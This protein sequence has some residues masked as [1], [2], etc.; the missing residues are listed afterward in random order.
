MRFE[1]FEIFRP[2]TSSLRSSRVARR[3]PSF[4]ET[5]EARQLLSASLAP[6]PYTPTASPVAVSTISGTPVTVPLAGLPAQ[7]PNAPPISTYIISSA[8][9]NGK[10]LPFT[11]AFGA[12]VYAPAP[13]FVGTDTFM[14]EAVVNSQ[15]PGEPPA[16]SNPATVT[17]NVTYNYTTLSRVAVFTNGRGQI[18]NIELFW[19]GPLNA[20]LARSKAPYEIESA[21]PKGSFTGPG[22]GSI[23]IRKVRYNIHTDVVKLTPRPFFSKFKNTQLLVLGSGPSAVTAST[24][25]PISGNNGAS[26]DA[27]RLLRQSVGGVIQALPG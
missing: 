18:S 27:T 3:R 14:Y 1:W 5:L 8:P 13:G 23:A 7:T 10:V 11:P 22:S 26:S 20:S 4:G 15:M 2:R 16:F 6:I 24:G 9:S 21:N 17:V 25:R 12:V 19:S